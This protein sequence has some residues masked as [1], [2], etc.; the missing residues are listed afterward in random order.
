MRITKLQLKIARNWGMKTCYCSWGSEKN[1]LGLIPPSS[2]YWPNSHIG[3]TGQLYSPIYPSQ[4]DTTTNITLRHG[5]NTHK[6]F[7]VLCLSSRQL[8]SVT[9]LDS[10]VKHNWMQLNWIIAGVSIPSESLSSFGIHQERHC[11]SVQFSSVSLFPQYQNH[12]ITCTVT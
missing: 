2:I 9:E 3:S 5:P 11:G 1:I 8:R 10:T 6:T 12:R 4:Y 7:T